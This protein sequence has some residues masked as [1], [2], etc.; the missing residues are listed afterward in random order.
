MLEI[1]PITPTLGAEVCGIDLSADLSDN[2]FGAVRDAF[3][4]HSVLLFRGQEMSPEQQVKFSARF[5]KLMVHVLKESLLEG[6]PEIYRLSNVVKDG[7]PQGRANAGQYWHSDLS[8]EAQPSLGSVLYGIEVPKVGGD[9]L[10]TSTA[11]AYETLSPTMQ[12]FLKGLTGVH[13]F[14]HAFRGRT[15]SPTL[16][17]AKLEER[18]PVEHPVVRRHQ[19]NG[20]DCL[21]VNP[22]FTI[23]IKELEDQESE[24]LLDF[25]YAHMT[26]PEYVLRHKWL[27]GDVVLWDN[28]ALMHTGVNDYDAASPRHMHRTTIEDAA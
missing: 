7:I 1:T 11:H 14:A 9:T 27:P 10:F 25:L 4:Q 20:R 12:S 21:F 28:R 17:Q 18:P 26:K 16:S 24:I 15:T 6:H 3:N 22:G 19:D 2:L 13:Q 8:Y 23:N 5:G